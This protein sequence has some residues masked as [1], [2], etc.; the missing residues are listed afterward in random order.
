MA[1]SRQG[2][3]AWSALISASAALLVGPFVQPS[4]SFAATCRQPWPACSTRWLPP[5]T[6]LS[7]LGLIY[8]L[9][10]VLTILSVLT[11][12]VLVMRDQRRTRSLVNTTSA[13]VAITGLLPILGA[14]RIAA[15]HTPWL[16]G[17]QTIVDYTLPALLIAVI[18]TLRQREMPP[19]RSDQSQSGTNAGT[20][21]LALAALISVLAGALLISTGAASSALPA[22][23]CVDWPRCVDGRLFFADTSVASWLHGIHR[24]ASAVWAWAVIA[25]ALL[26]RPRSAPPLARTL[27]LWTL[28]VGV[29]QVLAGGNLVVAR[30]AVAFD[31]LHLV[32]GLVVW[33]LV[34]STLVVVGWGFVPSRATAAI[35]GHVPSVI[36]QRQAPVPH[37][38]TPGLPQ[39][40]SPGVATTLPYTVNLPT[41]AAP[42]WRHLRSTLNDYVALTKPGILVLLLT[43]T[44]CAMLIASPRAISLPLIAATLLG[45]AL[46]AGGANALNCFI[47]RDI[48]AIMSRTRHRASAA[49][50]ISPRSVLIFGLLLSAL[51]VLELGLVANW[52]AAGLALAGNLFYVLVYTRWLK[53]ATPHN[54]V[55]GGA[56][57][58]VPP[59]VGWAAAT[60][61][62]SAAAWILFAIIFAWTP[63]HFWALALLKQGEYGRAAVPMLPVV[64]GEEATRRQIVL[65][66][67]LLFAVCLVLVPL[68]FGVIYLVAAIALNGIFLGFAI[69]LL[70]RPSKHL[71][72]RLF[73]YS[74]WYLALIFAAA[75]VDRLI[76]A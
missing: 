11:T 63:P 73:F 40:M 44:A 17:L 37:H 18:F 69:H 51:A 72:R 31:L 30:G 54:I 8:T 49:G 61:T 47:D 53:R 32:A 68:G 70:V 12:A 52:Q 62:L 59:L 38:A 75:V 16:V 4:D 7:T 43:T 46:A 71:A 48:D 10:L 1:A 28:A 64:A 60:G 39:S 27:S 45:G 58:A 23:G 3:I 9:L 42:S 56:A 33:L 20:R 36:D 22:T 24:L 29:V 67:L 21:R 50:R 74:L 6:D 25:V 15:S 66:S 35:P 65:Y 5:T 13:A 57:G 55:I 14:T 2:A 76:L 34:V 19:V 26:A 41:F